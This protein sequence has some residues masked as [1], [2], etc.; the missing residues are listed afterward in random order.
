MT[1]S[2]NGPVTL[3]HHSWEADR[4]VF[5]ASKRKE[6]VIGEFS[7]LAALPVEDLAVGSPVLVH[8]PAPDFSTGGAEKDV[9]II[10]SEEAI[11]GLGVGR[12]FPG[13]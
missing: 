11:G 13:A 8:E 9:G 3:E 4:L 2:F 7:V 1:D 10:D 6:S 5:V 12:N